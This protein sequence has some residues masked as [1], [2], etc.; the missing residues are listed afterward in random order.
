M[1]GGT[2]NELRSD[3]ELIEVCNSGNSR[4]AA[5]AYEVLYTRHREYVLR[6]AMRYIRDR[7]LALDVLQETFLYLLRKFPP[8]GKGLTLSARLTTLLYPVAK[9]G[10]I[11]ARRKAD[12]FEGSESV[13]PDQLPGDAPGDIDELERALSGLPDEHREV[14]LLRFVDDMPLDDIAA[15]LAIPLGTVKSRIHNAIK[16]LR[17]DPEIEKFFGR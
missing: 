10:A 12:R 3:A 11:N 17:S 9:N 13:S 6:V 14:L 5:G 1:A 4:D 15:A 16:R 2:K 8:T 7:E